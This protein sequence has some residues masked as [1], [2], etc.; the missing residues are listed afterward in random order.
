[1]STLDSD[2]MDDGT[3]FTKEELD[4]IFDVTPE[5]NNNKDNSGLNMDSP[6]AANEAAKEAATLETSTQPD[7]NFDSGLDETALDAEITRR[8]EEQAALFQH[9]ATAAPKPKPTKPTTKPS[10]KQAG[11]P[12]LNGKEGGAE[13]FTGSKVGGGTAAGSLDGRKVVG[14]GSVSSTYPDR[15]KAPAKPKETVSNMLYIYATDFRKAPLNAE[16]W[17]LI[18]DQLIEGLLNDPTPYNIAK[19]GYDST[20][21]CGYIGCRDQRSADWCQ[22]LVLDME[23]SYRAWARDEKP[24]GQICRLFLP[25]RFQKLTDHQAMNQLLKHN[26]PFK[27]GT[28][29]LKRAEIVQGGRALYIEMDPNSFGYVKSKDYR[30]PFLLMD[31]DCQ[32]APASP[33][34]KLP[35]VNTEVPTIS[36]R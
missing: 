27:A 8:S 33:K 28:L 7:P 21:R 20:Y 4:K 3:K 34:R 17:K 32:V 16:D 2:D 13:G 36:L 9:A 35:H 1:M 15:A 24:M 10:D 29:Q 26:A 30:L 6:T 18:D 14:A 23:G 5:H 12:A 19:S 31:V 11:G 22:K 25:S